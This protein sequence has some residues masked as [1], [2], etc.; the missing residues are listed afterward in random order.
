MT[1]TSVIAITALAVAGLS[2]APSA[3]AFDEWAGVYAGGGLGYS[4]NSYDLDVAPG[5]KLSHDYNGIV[6][7][8]YVGFNWQEDRF[9]Y[10]V[11]T[12]FDYQFGEDTKTSA[13]PFGSTTLDTAGRWTTTMRGRV[14]FTIDRF[15]AYGTAGVAFSGFDD[16]YTNYD[17]TGAVIDTVS[18]GDVQVGWAAGVGA[19][20]FI[21]ERFTAGVEY[22]YT[23]FSFD[24]G[25]SGVDNS[26]NTL[27][28]RF[29]V[30]F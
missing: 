28:A 20:A 23:S 12:D 1:R 24:A 22:R 29:G 21:T 30:H 19:E 8:P 25:G 3:R 14:G 10:G 13:M 15:L 18:I 9:V 27:K 26:T 17:P 16:T 11:E 7:G 5:A 6:L 4:F 2:A